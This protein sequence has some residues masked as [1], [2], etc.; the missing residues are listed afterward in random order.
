M[1]GRNL[2]R[3]MS[4]KTTLADNSVDVV[5][6]FQSFHWFEPN[7]ALAEFHRILREG[8]RAALV[9]NERDWGDAFT[10]AYGAELKAALGEDHPAFSRQ[11]AGKS[12]TIIANSP[13]F[14]NAR[15]LIFANSKRMTLEGLIGAALS[16][17]YVP[18]SGEAH[19]KLMLGLKRIHA[20]FSD[21]SGCVEMVY[22][23]EVMLAERTQ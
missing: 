13:L 22:K 18:K 21:A 6:A 10:A 2:S 4:E 7:A 3:N 15:E 16:A 19:E 17:S 20:Q 12:S 14:R 1:L 8:G 5:T 11:N 9:W 23:T